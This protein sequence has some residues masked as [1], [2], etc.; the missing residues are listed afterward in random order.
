[1][2]LLNHQKM[3]QMH[4]KDLLQTNHQLSYHRLQKNY[5]E[6]R[7]TPIE[8][9]PIRHLHRCSTCAKKNLFGSAV[10]KEKRESCDYE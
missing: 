5:A 7:L 9:L 10:W 8:Y 2:Y 4:T 6:P 1:M 3:Q